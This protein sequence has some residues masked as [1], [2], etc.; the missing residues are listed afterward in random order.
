MTKLTTY[1]DTT[2]QVWYA[3]EGDRAEDGRAIGQG[4][5]PEDAKADFWYQI[6]GSAADLYYLDETEHW[7]LRQDWAGVVFDTKEAAIEYA[8]RHEWQVK[9]LGA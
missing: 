5:T 4:T 7:L 9:T 1:Y 3:Y 8:D 6:N 2:D